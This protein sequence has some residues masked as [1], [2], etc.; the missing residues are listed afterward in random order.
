V[1]LLDHHGV[2][3]DLRISK[4]F[5]IVIDWGAQHVERAEVVKPGV[6]RFG[7]KNGLQGCY[8]CSGL[9]LES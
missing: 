6:A 4:D 3:F 8:R 2:M 7:E 1:L 5:G 9:L